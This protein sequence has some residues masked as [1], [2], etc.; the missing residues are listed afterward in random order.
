MD[1]DE[2]LLGE[3]FRDADVKCRDNRIARDLSH[4][5][6]ESDVA[7]Y[8]R[9]RIGRGALHAHRISFEDWLT[10]LDHRRVA[11]NASAAAD[12]DG[13]RL[14]EVARCATNNEEWCTTRT[15]VPLTRRSR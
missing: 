2:P 5:E 14:P 1:R 10:I 8:E 3:P 6:V 11:G 12:E 4:R 9:L 13:M 7:F 15:A